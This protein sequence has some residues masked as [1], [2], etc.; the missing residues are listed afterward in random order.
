MDN[1]IET[2]NAYQGSLFIASI[3][4]AL[5]NT[6]KIQPCD[7]FVGRELLENAA[8]ELG[9]SEAECNRRAQAKK[10]LEWFEEIL[11]GI[12]FSF[13]EAFGSGLRKV[14]SKEMLFHTC[15]FFLE[16]A[17][18][19]ENSDSEGSFAYHMNIESKAVTCQ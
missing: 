1:V 9:L 11:K 2:I 14:S 8:E 7:G 10:F 3:A 15:G 5:D 16:P 12:G 6:E 4:N 19:L 13:D 18:G 17:W